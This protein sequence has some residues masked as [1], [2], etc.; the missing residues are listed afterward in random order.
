[1][2]KTVQKKLKLWFHLVPAGDSLEHRSAIDPVVDGLPQLPRHHRRVLQL[3]Q[4]A[5]CEDHPSHF[6]SSAPSAHQPILIWNRKLVQGGIPC[7]IISPFPYQHNTPS[8][9][10]WQTHAWTKCTFGNCVSESLRFQTNCW[11]GNS[12]HRKLSFCDT[13]QYVL[14]EPKSVPG[15]WI[16]AS[17]G[18]ETSLVYPNHE[19]VKIVILSLISTDITDIIRWLNQLF[20]R[21]LHSTSTRT[22][23][24]EFGAWFDLDYL[25]FIRPICHHNLLSSAH[26]EF[27]QSCQP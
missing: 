16:R 8:S 4:D 1:M 9:T 20:G 27:H 11:A 21:R 14:P 2:V 3:H 12:I 10:H 19:F 18:N 23:R 17:T 13:P 25:P 26:S 15:A 5:Q 7:I 6:S 22:I 24:I